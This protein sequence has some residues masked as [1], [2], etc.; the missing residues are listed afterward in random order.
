MYSTWPRFV[1]GSRCAK[2]LHV[3]GPRSPKMSSSR[4]SESFLT[5]HDG[6]ALTCI[7]SLYGVYGIAFRRRRLANSKYVIL[8]SMSRLRKMQKANIVMANRN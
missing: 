4:V 8:G 7:M 5:R 1:F 2:C 3:C 6:C